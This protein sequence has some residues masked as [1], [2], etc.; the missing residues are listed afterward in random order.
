MRLKTADAAG[1]DSNS[2]GYFRT[3]CSRTLS[4]PRR[5]L[6]EQGLPA[7][8]AQD[9]AVGSASEPAQPG[10]AFARG[11]PSRMAIDVATSVSSV[12]E[13][14][15]T[16]RRCSVTENRTRKGH[17]VGD[18]QAGEKDNEKPPPQCA[19]HR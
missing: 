5:G 4:R 7:C 6:I 18:R 12:I 1:M 15:P 19:R 9:E 16:W 8:P 13:T 2:I 14:S 10:G 11:E 17:G 3:D